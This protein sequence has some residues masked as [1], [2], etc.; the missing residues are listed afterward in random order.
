M[1]AATVLCCMPGA[2][3]EGTEGTDI[4]ERCPAAG[5]ELGTGISDEQTDASPESVHDLGL[6]SKGDISVLAVTPSEI[7]QSVFVNGICKITVPGTYTLQEDVSGTVL[8]T[9]D[10]SVV[11]NGN[12]HILRPDPDNAADQKYGVQVTDGTASAT[13]E[14]FGNITGFSGP[15]IHSRAFRTTTIRNNIIYGCGDE[16]ITSLRSTNCQGIYAASQKIVVTSNTVT[17]CGTPETSTTPGPGSYGILVMGYDG[18]VSNNTVTGCGKI[19][20]SRDGRTGSYG[21]YAKTGLLVS[22]NTVTDCGKVTTSGAE[23][24]SGTGIFAQGGIISGNTVTDCGKTVGAGGENIGNGIFGMSGTTIEKNIVTN[25]GF[26]NGESDLS[27]GFGI[28]AEDGSIRD[29]VVSGCGRESPMGYG[30]QSVAGA[31]VTDNRVSDS[32]IDCVKGGFGIFLSGGFSDLTLADNEVTGCGVSRAEG[33][34]IVAM[35]AGSRTGSKSVIRNNTITGTSATACLKLNSVSALTMTEN[36]INADGPALSLTGGLTGASRIYNNAFNTS[37][38]VHPDVTMA[39]IEKYAWNAETPVFARNIIGGEW[40]AGN[41]WGSTDGA[42]GYSDTHSSV[43]G[44]GKEAFEVVAGSGVYDAMPLCGLSESGGGELKITGGVGYTYDRTTTT[45]TI[46]APGEYWFTGFAH[47]KPVIIASDDVA[48]DGGYFSISVG[49]KTPGKTGIFAEDR[50]NIVVKNCQVKNGDIG[51]NVTGREIVITGNTVTGSALYGIYTG[52]ATVT[53]NSVTVKAVGIHGSGIVS[54]NTVAAP[55]GIEVTREAEDVFIKSNTVTSTTT[56]ISVPS[57]WGGR[58]TLSG[59]VVKSDATALEVNGGTGSVYNNLFRAETYVAGTAPADYAWNITP[60]D[61]AGR[62]IVLGKY[63][64]G[65]YW[66]NAAGNGWSDTTTSETGYSE[67]PFEVKTGVYDKTPLCSVELPPVSGVELTEAG[68]SGYA[69]ASGKYTITVPGYYYFK[70]QPHIVSIESDDVVMDGRDVLLTADTRSTVVS[71]KQGKQYRNVTVKNCYIDGGYIGIRVEGTDGADVSVID[72]TLKNTKS[73]GVYVKKGVVDGNIL[74]NCAYGG[75]GYHSIV[76]Y[77]YAR[78][79]NNIVS[80]ATKNGIYYSNTLSDGAG[81]AEIA[82]NRVQDG[83]GD[84]ISVTGKDGNTTVTGNT[85]T[86]MRH[87]GIFITPGRNNPDIDGA[88]VRVLDNTVTDC[89]V[90]IDSTVKTLEL[91]RGNVVTD[92]DTGISGDG[93]ITGNTVQECMVGI[94]VPAGAATPATITDNRVSGAG[95]CAVEVDGSSGSVYN[96]VFA[97]RTHVRGSAVDTY[98]WN[99]TP[100]RGENIV[101]GAYRAGNWWGSPD[102]TDGYSEI[103]HAV[104]GYLGENPANCYEPAPGVCDYYPLVRTTD[105]TLDPALHVADGDVVLD[106]PAVFAAHYTGT[107]IDRCGSWTWTFTDATGTDTQNFTSATMEIE[108]TF[109]SPGPAVVAL[110]VADR[111]GQTVGTSR[112]KGVVARSALKIGIENLEDG[113]IFT[114]DTG[115]TL[116]ADVPDLDEPENATYAWECVGDDVATFSSP[117]AMETTV[118]FTRPGISG[119]KLTVTPGGADAEKYPAGSVV[120]TAVVT[121]TPS[122]PTPPEPL[123]PVKPKIDSGSPDVPTI[124]PEISVDRQDVDGDAGFTVTVVTPVSGEVPKFAATM[125]RPSDAFLTLN[126]TPENLKDEKH[127]QYSAVFTVCIPASTVPE[128]EKYNVRVYRFNTVSAAWEALPTTWVKTEA[129]VHHYEVKTPGF[130]VFTVVRAVPKGVPASSSG[131]DGWSDR[132]TAV[133]N[134]DGVA[135]FNGVIRT[136]SLGSGAAG[137]LVVLDGDIAIT[138]AQEFYRVVAVTVRDPSVTGGADIT[139]CVPNGVYENAGYSKDDIA[140]ALYTGEKWEVQSTCCTGEEKGMTC[141]SAHIPAPGTV[142]VVYGKGITASSD[143]AA[144]N[145]TAP[146]VMPTPIPTTPT[147]PEVVETTAPITAGT[148]TAAPTG[149]ASTPGFGIITALAGAGAATLLAG[150][151]N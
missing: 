141:Y 136:V 5:S 24:V 69:Y 95:G 31:E 81:G 128:N 1:V 12:G 60:T 47:V 3:A 68:G 17:D 27:F 26:S 116:R 61:M 9:V 117:D 111:D 131:S 151:R 59:N 107:A 6:L 74:T 83:R 92:C 23:E 82:G 104:N 99:I 108:H 33:Y 4:E 65:N 97:T 129:G 32:G 148:A 149:P 7:T 73:Y 86:T 132:E 137:A 37:S 21:I 114:V 96:N 102:G 55:I 72:N 45:Y 140:L 142:A 28:R 147:V 14:N 2:A 125:G 39:A 127:L 48:L 8:I 122:V 62:N 10:G 77:D 11:L 16:P 90:G 124:I 120:C 130:S 85:V 13:I 50:S 94:A 46:T 15:G 118:T 112:W 43:K 133:C 34:G 101:G 35:N 123:N 63:I 134:A 150:R 109:T 67:T 58:A 126:I 103:N 56:G 138:P 121:A 18:T 146:T 87:S 75:I 76:V 66:T 71:T 84:G 105:L 64:A 19:T 51:I 29:N 139:F 98:A 145:T 57:E 144:G 88:T 22:D 93:E 70:T 91:T 115:V 100:T 44:F 36:R 106:M 38:Y 41:W 40:T 25:S 113:A 143:S 80:G 42:S 89:E 135:R 20:E 78:V 119:I 79:T 53:D 52:D 30:I 110:T 54:R 49:T